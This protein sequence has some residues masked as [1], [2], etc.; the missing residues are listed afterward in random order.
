MINISLEAQKFRVV[1]I[2]SSNQTVSPQSVKTTNMQLPFCDAK[3]PN[4]KI[5]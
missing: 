5:S 3:L 2:L 1:L 4:H